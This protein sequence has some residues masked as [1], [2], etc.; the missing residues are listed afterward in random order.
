MR[1]KGHMAATKRALAA[2]L[3]EAYIVLMEEGQ[4]TDDSTTQTSS[5]E[6][7]R[8]MLQTS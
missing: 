1:I 7:P 6:V 4:M 5:V 8:R 3:A 2:C